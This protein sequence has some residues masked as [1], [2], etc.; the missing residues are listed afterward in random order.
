[1]SQ[2]KEEI[3]ESKCG[4]WIPFLLPWALRQDHQPLDGED[5][6]DRQF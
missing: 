3:N 4:V 6:K 2:A 1:M 5:L